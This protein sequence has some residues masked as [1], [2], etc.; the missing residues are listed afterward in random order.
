MTT[1]VG[2]LAASPEARAQSKDDVVNADALFNAAKALL[3]AGQITDACAKFAESKRLAPGLGVTLYL[4]DCYERIGRTASAWTEFRA[5]EGL[6]RERSD[7]RAEVARARA[8]ALEPKLERLTIDIAPTVPRS[9]LRL[10]LD[11]GAVPAEEWGLPLAVDPGN[12][13]V[14]ASAPNHPDRTFAFHIGPDNQT[15][16]VRIET[17]EEPAAPQPTPTSPPIPTSPVAPTSASNQPPPNPSEK[18]TP[19]ES[20]AAL[21]WTGIGVG[22]LGLVGIGVGAAFGLTAKSELDR[23]NQSGDCNAQ[24]SCS[25]AGQKLRHEAGDSATLSTFFFALGGVALA[26]G[27]VLYSIPL[28]RSTVVVRLSPMPGGGAA[29]IRTTF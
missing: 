18:H 13:V 27:V 3:D 26:G 15:A 19:L 16:A 22:A 5:A 17:L 25:P 23:S 10:L 24:D 1:A 21:R 8:E 4:A 7:R 6:A 20:G 12:H 11:G 28:R 2:M 29:A 9:G 14:V